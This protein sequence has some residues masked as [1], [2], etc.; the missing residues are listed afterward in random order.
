MNR[1]RAL[2]VTQGLLAALFLFAG[3]SKFATSA[4]TLAA[5]SPFPAG[6]LR[7]VGACEVLGAFG[8]VLPWALRIRPMLTPLAA[9]GLVVI[10]AGAAASTLG[11]G[12]GPLALLPAAV[13]LLAALVAVGRRPQTPRAVPAGPLLRPAA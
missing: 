1:N 3:G 2:W 10:M 8:L 13:G 5:M 7:F 12:G 4:E 11:V 9:T 6:F